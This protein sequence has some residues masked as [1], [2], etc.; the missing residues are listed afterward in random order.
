MIKTAANLSKAADCLWQDSYKEAQMPNP[1][2]LASRT[3]HLPENTDREFRRSKAIWKDSV[4]RP[5][6][7]LQTRGIKAE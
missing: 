4:R 1:E 2:E 5:E 7:I 3:D 6:I